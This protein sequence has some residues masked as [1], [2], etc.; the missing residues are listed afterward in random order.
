[1]QAEP[2][3]DVYANAA[4]GNTTRAKPR[5]PIEPLR[6]L[7]MR[8]SIRFLMPTA[9]GYALPTGHAVTAITKLFDDGV[10]TEKKAHIVIAITLRRSCFRLGERVGTA[11]SRPQNS[12]FRT[13]C[14]RSCRR[15]ISRITR[16]SL[17]YFLHPCPRLPLLPA[18]SNSTTRQPTNPAGQSRSLRPSEVLIAV[19][20]PEPL[21]CHPI[22][23]LPLRSL[24]LDRRHIRD[25]QNAYLGFGGHHLCRRLAIPG[26]VIRGG[27]AFGGRHH[28]RVKVASGHPRAHD[29]A[30]RCGAHCR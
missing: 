9:Q 16:G 12:R 29:V 4:F 1:M 10:A 7:C 6:I 26:A 3:A 13:D 28:K 27:A 15:A 30:G 22:L 20:P 14:T 23:P 8:V 21:A 25:Y 5:A 24:A 18:R 2:C 11:P 19:T 17:A